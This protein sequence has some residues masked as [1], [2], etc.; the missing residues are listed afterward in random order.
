MEHTINLSIQGMHCDG[1][2]RRVTNAITAIE[3]ARPESVQVG[4]AKVNIDRS[5]VSA[6]QVVNAISRIGFAAHV[7]N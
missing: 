4:S 6:E 7:E 5:Q 2:V 1:C 3:G